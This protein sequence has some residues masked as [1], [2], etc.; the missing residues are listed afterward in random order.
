MS[1]AHLLCFLSALVVCSSQFSLPNVPLARPPALQVD[2][3]GRAFVAAGDQLLRLSSTDLLPEQNITLSSDAVNISLSSGGEWLVV[4]TTDLSCS[5]HNTSNLSALSVV[6]RSVLVG[7]DR[8]IALFTTRNSFYVGSFDV[9]GVVATSPMM[10]LSQTYGIERLSISQR[11]TIYDMNNLLTVL[12]FKRDYFSGFVKGNY[13]YFMVS[14]H[15]PADERAVRIVRACHCSGGSTCP[16]LRI[17]SEEVIRCGQRVAGDGD[18]LCGVS[19]VEDFAGTSG[20]SIV[21]S[22]CRP[23][24][25]SSNVVCLVSLSEVTR[26]MDMR[27]DECRNNERRRTE[28]SWIKRIRITTEC[29]KI[30]VHHKM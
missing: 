19:V 4:C 30:K 29:S 17:L 21:I 27:A 1:G 5:V 20:T 6:T 3:K 25:S 26:I 18:G 10:K 14:D 15:D 11:A 22:R 13:V 9:P 12:N 24:F 2:A 16:S 7:A 28:I 8:G 23:R